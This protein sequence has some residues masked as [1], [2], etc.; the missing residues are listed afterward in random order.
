MST[1]TSVQNL[2]INKLTKAQFDTITPS[3]TE[4]YEITDLSS[5]LDAKVTYS[6]VITDYTA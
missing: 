4:A 1:E 3:A 2:K 6:M 5:I